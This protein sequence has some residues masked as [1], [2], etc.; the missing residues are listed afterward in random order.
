MLRKNKYK[1]I[2]KSKLKKLRADFAL[3][4]LSKPSRE[5]TAAMI[6]L[7]AQIMREENIN[8]KK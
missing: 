8:N 3:V 4:E 7:N 2:T 1:F 5:R 6:K